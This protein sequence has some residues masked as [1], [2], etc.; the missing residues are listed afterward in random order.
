MKS[1]MILFGALA[2]GTNFG[3]TLANNN[4]QN[5]LNVHYENSLPKPNVFGGGFYFPVA[6]G[7]ESS[8]GLAP[9]ENRINI[10]WSTRNFIGFIQNSL[11]KDAQILEFGYNILLSS[12]TNYFYGIFPDLGKIFLNIYKNYNDITWNYEDYFTKQIPKTENYLMYWTMGY[13]N[14]LTGEKIDFVMKSQPI[15]KNILINEGWYMNSLIF[16]IVQ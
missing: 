14:N 15:P 1:L 11:P 3:F 2:T 8:L 10:L 12:E 9:Y 6:Q 5:N 16:Y 7:V 13:T 4:E